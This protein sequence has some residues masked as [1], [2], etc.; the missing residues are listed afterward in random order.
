MS[1]HVWKQGAVTGKA[2]PNLP[3][4]SFINLYSVPCCKLFTYYD[5][6]AAIIRDCSWSIKSVILPPFPSLHL[7]MKIGLAVD[8]QKVPWPGLGP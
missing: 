3:L 8:E 5:L 1:P 6:L 4:S 7:F 2:F